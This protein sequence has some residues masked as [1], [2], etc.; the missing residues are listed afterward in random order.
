MALSSLLLGATVQMLLLRKDREAGWG[1]GRVGRS[2][3]RMG[4]YCNSHTRQIRT[5]GREGDAL[6]LA[7]AAAG[8]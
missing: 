1:G 3:P 4:C 8:T 6:Q 2:G 5:D 7:F